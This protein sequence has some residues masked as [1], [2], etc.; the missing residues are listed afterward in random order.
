ME[1]SVK[2]MTEILD[3]IIEDH[4]KTQS[5]KVVLYNEN[6]EE[7]VMQ[8]YRPPEYNDFYPVPGPFLTW[9]ET[10]IKKFKKFLEKVDK[11]LEDFHMFIKYKNEYTLFGNCLVLDL[12]WK[13]LKLSVERKKISEKELKF[14]KNMCMNFNSLSNVYSHNSLCDSQDCLGFDMKELYDMNGISL[15]SSFDNISFNEDSD[16]FVTV[17][18]K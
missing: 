16:G 6:L 7:M 4:R 9:M 8:Q 18:N 2:L 11:N 1:K 12:E 14:L 13:T 5:A 10:N 3:E 17:G 15:K